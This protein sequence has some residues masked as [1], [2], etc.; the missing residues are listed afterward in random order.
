MRRKVNDAPEQRPGAETADAN[1]PERQ[2]PSVG[3]SDQLPMTLKAPPHRATPPRRGGAHDNATVEKGSGGT[4]SLEHFVHEMEAEQDEAIDAMLDLTGGTDECA[5]A[6]KEEACWGFAAMDGGSREAQGSS[7]SA[8]NADGEAEQRSG[9]KGEGPAATE[10]ADQQPMTL[11]E[12]AH[13]AASP[14]R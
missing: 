2:A 6:L 13:W 3:G 4:S 9:G 5:V 8:M 1:T 12:P 14:R 7:S 10:H 11:V